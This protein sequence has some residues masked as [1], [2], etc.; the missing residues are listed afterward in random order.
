MIAPQSFVA[1]ATVFVCCYIYSDCRSLRKMF[2]DENVL[3]LSEG[4]PS[5]VASRQLL[6][7]KYVALKNIFLSGEAFK[8]TRR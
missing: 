4:N 7:E 3:I 2:T 1:F 8:T 6:P 5:S